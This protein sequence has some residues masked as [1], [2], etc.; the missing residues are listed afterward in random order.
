MWRAMPLELSL[1]TMAVDLA[2]N[3][4]QVDVCG[5]TDAGRGRRHQI[6]LIPIELCGAGLLRS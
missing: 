4:N 1:N 5:H 2:Q 6:D 3:R